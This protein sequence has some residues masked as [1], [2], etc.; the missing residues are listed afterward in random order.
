MKNSSKRGEMSVRIADRQGTKLTERRRI[1]NRTSVD[2]GSHIGGKRRE[3]QAKI[4]GKK[5]LIIARI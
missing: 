1:A 5:T 3:P 4:R 2:F